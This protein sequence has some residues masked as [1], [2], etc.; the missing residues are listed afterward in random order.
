M[1]DIGRS[2]PNVFGTREP[3]S[4]ETQFPRNTYSFRVWVQTPYPPFYR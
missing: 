3:G 4:S 2:N 1:S